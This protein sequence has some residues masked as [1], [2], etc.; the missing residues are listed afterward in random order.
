MQVAEDPPKKA[1]SPPVAPVEKKK[2]KKKTDTDKGGATATAALA[3]ASEET[4]AAVAAAVAAGQACVKA[5]G[6]HGQLV[7]NVLE[8]APESGN[9]QAAWHDVIEA[10][11]AKSEAVKAA[12][13]KVTDAV[14]KLD[15]LEALVEKSDASVR[16]GDS[17][18]TGDAVKAHRSKLCEVNDEI[19]SAKKESYLVE[20]YRDL[21]ED[22]RQQFRKE[23]AALLPGLRQHSDGSHDEPLSQEEM[24]VFITHAYKKVASLQQQLGKLKLLHQ[25][26]DQTQVNDRELRKQVV[27]EEVV[28]AELD[29]Q[30]RQLEV[31][32][33]Q[34]VA[35]I[36][37]EMEAEMRGQLRRQAAAHTDHIKDALEVQE[38]EISRKFGRKIDE[39]LA[40]EKAN[41]K[42]ELA[43][44]SGAVDGLKTAVK[45]REA[46]QETVRGA[47]ELW[48]ACS[49][50]QRALEAERPSSGLLPLKDEVDA[51][52][53]AIKSVRSDPFVDAVVDSLPTEALH[54]GVYTDQTLRDRFFRVEAMARR[55][56]LVGEEGGSLLLYLLSYLQS[57][58]VVTPSTETMPDPAGAAVD[59]STLDTFD[60]VW[61]SRG[62]VERGDLEQ[63]VKYMTLLR[64]EPK[65]M[66]K[67]WVREA[68]LL[69]EARQVCDALMAHASAYG[70]EAFPTTTK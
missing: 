52:K 21:V 22:G 10:A 40:E 66:A 9:D 36:R 61:L 39:A 11:T 35:A 60:I 5:I 27:T 48:L 67:E 37:E 29:A 19:Q 45:D 3:K 58:L 38:M 13:E 24:D 8:S 12:Q 2:K 44:L 33:Q 1:D 47:Q 17:A 16:G 64:G 4:A 70:L 26:L 6:K 63:A 55:T 28:Q 53:S 18:T 7:V 46:V 23:A 54:R 50:L 49:S 51:I 69:L 31:E 59:L 34:R 25:Q 57:A 68:R 30:R 41:Y 65:N 32:H 20:Q 14:M 43:K 15:S 42:A 56:A 62:C